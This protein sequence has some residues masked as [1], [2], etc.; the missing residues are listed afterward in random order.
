MV[1]GIQHGVRHALAL[2]ELRE[3]LGLFDGDGADQHGLALGVAVLDLLDD[4][5]ELARLRLIDD[6][7]VIDADNGPVRRD[8]DDVELVDGGEFLLLGHGRAG[9]AGKLGVQAEEI[10]ERDG[11]KRLVLAGDGH[12]LLGLDSLMQALVIAAAVHQAAGEFVDDDDLAVL[13]DIV[14]IALHDAAGLHGLIDVVHERRVLHIGQILH[15]EILFGLGDAAGRERDGA[16]LLLDIVIAVEVVLNF[17][18]VRRGKHLAAQAG[19]EEVGHFIELCRFL[20]LA[21]DDKRRTGLIDEDGVDLVDDDEVMAALD[22]VLLIKSHVVAQIVKAELVVRAVGDIGSIGGA[23][24]VR[25]EIVDDQADRE[26]EEAID[27]PHPFRVA[28][29]QIVVD[30]DDVHALS[31]QG[32]EIGRQDGDQRF[33]L[34]GLHLRDAALMQHDAADELHAVRPHAEHAVRRLAADGKRLGQEVVEVLAALIALAEL[35]RLFTQLLVRQRL[36]LVLHGLD[37]RDERHKLLYLTL[38]AGAEDFLNDSHRMQDLSVG[39]SSEIIS[40]SPT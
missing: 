40:Q 17:L 11:R 15:A 35:V 1:L 38:R 18:L 4:G 22:H 3:I 6:V 28:L 32:I 23:A 26:A 25:L 34:A 31:R 36:H 10:L 33:A 9:H 29:G 2:E 13:D 27:L 21:G 8:L 14:D 24:L 16:G 30:R 37:A 12:A 19:N 7:V 5:A 39:F 20:A